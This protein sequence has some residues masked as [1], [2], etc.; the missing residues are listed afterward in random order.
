M[1]RIA[2]ALVLACILSQVPIAHAAVGIV[3]LVKVWGYKQEPSA[4]N[5]E[6]LYRRDAVEM[7]QRLRTPDGGALHVRFVDDTELRLGSAAEVTIDRFVF[8]PSTGAGSLRA[9]MN[10]GMMRFITGRMAKEGV[11][12]GTPTAV[13]GIRGTDFV[14][15]VADDGTTTVAVY[16]G[17]VVITPRTGGDSETVAAGQ[18]ARVALN[19]AIVETHVAAPPPDEGLDDGAGHDGYADGN[20]GDGSDSGGG[21]SGGGC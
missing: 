17:E 13:I 18:N 1:K 6:A 8:D 10:K 21:D 15:E 4:T 19:A 16:E 3:S 12:I 11:R 9:E 14:I 7:N 5:W 20:G 2:A